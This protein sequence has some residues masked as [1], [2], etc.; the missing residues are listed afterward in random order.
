MSDGKCRLNADCE[1]GEHDPADHPCGHLPEKPGEFCRFCGDP[2]PLDG[3]PCPECW[4]TL[5][6]MPL[7]DLKALFARDGISIDLPGEAS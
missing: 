3:S 7:A 2:V 4:V 1:F 6:G 5:E